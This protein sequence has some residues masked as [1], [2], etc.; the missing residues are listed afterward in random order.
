MIMIFFQNTGQNFENGRFLEEET[1]K[2][3]ARGDNEE[4]DKI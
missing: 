1:F 4:K 3:V 2:L